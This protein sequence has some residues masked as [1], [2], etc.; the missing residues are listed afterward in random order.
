MTSLTLAVAEHAIAAAQGAASQQGL[1]VVVTVVDAGVQ[2]VL[3]A[4]QDGALIAAVD[5]SLSK[6]RTTLFFGGTATADLAG[7]T[8]PGGPLFGFE[9]AVTVP[10]A[11]LGGAVPVRDAHGEVIGA[12]GVGGGTA[13][14]DHAIAA[15]AAA[16]AATAIGASA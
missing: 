2:P 7:A 12:V 13:E 1:A 8:A 11:F 6:A 3:I 9:H 10:L 16:A 5:A 4:R 15:A 14:Q